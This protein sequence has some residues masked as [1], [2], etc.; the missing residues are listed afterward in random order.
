MVPKCTLYSLPPLSSATWVFRIRLGFWNLI[1]TKWNSF[2]HNDIN[3][4]LVI[5]FCVRGIQLLFNHKIT[6]FG[7]ASPRLHFFNFDSSLP[8]FKRCKLNLNSHPPPLPLPPSPPP[9]IL[10]AVISA[11]K[12]HKKCSKNVS[13][14]Y[15]NT[16]TIIY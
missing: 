1:W 9:F 14:V 16:N 2:Q 4:G 5:N 3:C 6:K 13:Q 11:C 15:L 8:F 10:P 12:N 7:S